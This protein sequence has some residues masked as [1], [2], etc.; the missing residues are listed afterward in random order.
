MFLDHSSSYDTTNLEC[1]CFRI[2]VMVSYNSLCYATVSLECVC[3]CFLATFP[4]ALLYDN[5]KNK[6]IYFFLVNYNFNSSHALMLMKIIHSGLMLSVRV[7]I[8]WLYFK[9]ICEHIPCIEPQ[10][11]DCIF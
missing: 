10:H 6:W 4:V 9:Q 11:S 3:V 7:N 2:K 5:I 8:G 1:V